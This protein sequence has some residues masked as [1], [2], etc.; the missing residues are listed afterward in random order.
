MQLHPGSVEA[1]A[2]ELQD[3][4]V[5][6]H[7]ITTDRAKGYFTRV[8]QSCVNS[9]ITVTKFLK[10]LA[11]ARKT[12][13]LPQTEVA[14]EMQLSSVIDPLWLLLCINGRHLTTLQH[15]DLRITKSDCE[16]FACLKKRYSLLRSEVAFIKRI[17][18]RLGEIH[19][20]Q[21]NTHAPF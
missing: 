17:F 12:S 7:A 2:R 9:W 4:G 18:L 19:F 21:V 1:L 14:S 20:V 3:A 5:V 11:S 15:I 13:I 8:K 6:R 16:L 10:Q